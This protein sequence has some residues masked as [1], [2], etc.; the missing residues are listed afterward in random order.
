MLIMT[1][2]FHKLANTLILGCHFGSQRNRQ[3]A[4]KLTSAKI[5]QVLYIYSALNYSNAWSMQRYLW[6]CAL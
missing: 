5:K 3:G 2:F 6:Y 4:I 1:G